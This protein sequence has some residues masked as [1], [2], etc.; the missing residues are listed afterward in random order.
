MEVLLTWEGELDN[1]R[2]REVFGVQAVQASRL[3]SAF[4]AEYG[5]ALTRASPHAPVTPTKLFQPRFAGNS[6]DEYLRLVESVGPTARSF[7]VEDL[8]L[9]LSP[10]SSPLFALATRACLKQVGLQ[11]RYRSLA[12][13][14]G[15]DRLIY[16]HSLVR[17]ARRWHVRAWCSQRTAFRDFAL[18]RISKGAVEGSPSPATKEVDRDWNEFAK[19]E[20]VA[21]PELPAGQVQLLQDEY[22][23]SSTNRILEVRRCLVGYTV[24][25]LRLATDIR[26]H[27]PPE[28]Q[29]LLK[30][31]DEFSSV[32]SIRG[33]A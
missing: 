27:S 28:F 4:V 6:P 25:D 33:A 11:I 21:H 9:D 32:F 29:L 26:R 7:A 13:P 20:V 1:A 10:V 17:A 16:P 19:L 14:D 2:L 30:N 3:L 5:T 12:Q 18:G 22:L 23:G 8:R 15:H 31:A 24:Q